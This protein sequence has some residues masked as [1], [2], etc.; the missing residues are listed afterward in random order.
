MNMHVLPEVAPRKPALFSK[1]EYL[2]LVGMG[3]FRKP[4]ECDLVAGELQ[5]MNP[6][7]MGHQRMANHI[8]F[9]LKSMI[10]RDSLPLWVTSEVMIDLGP[11]TIRQ[12][13]VAITR[14]LSADAK[15]ALASETLIVVEV[16][17]ST[18]RLDL[19]EKL[20]DYATAGIP[21]YLVIDL[22]QDVVHVCKQPEDGDYVQRVVVPFGT[23]FDILESQ[24]LTV[25]KPD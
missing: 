10:D 8:L 19:G 1:D 6:I 9:Q 7:Y 2:E 22:K 15:L 13:D 14:Q 16:S 4:Y 23:A 5:R 3:A 24:K 17:D 18:L 11:T 21:H 20:L 12:A 25:S